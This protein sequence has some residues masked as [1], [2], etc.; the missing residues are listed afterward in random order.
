LRR[1]QLKILSLLYQVKLAPL[2]VRSRRPIVCV[3]RPPTLEIRIVR[4]MFPPMEL[5]A[6]VSFRIFKIYKTPTQCLPNVC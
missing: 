1:E 6:M 4:P 3:S 2:P 5:V